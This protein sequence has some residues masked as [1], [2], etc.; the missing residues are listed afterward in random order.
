MN[1]PR[2][3]NAI[4][5]I[6]YK[7][8]SALIDIIDNAVSAGANKVAIYVECVEGKSLNQRNNV[9]TYK[10]VD[11]GHG[12]DK[13]EIINAFKL[14]SNE[15]YIPYSLSKYGM[16]LK[17][18]GFSLGSRIQIVS[19]KNN[20]LSK[21][22]F[23]DQKVI[24]ED[25]DYVICSEDLEENNEYDNLLS[26]WSSGTVVKIKECRAVNHASAKTTINK[27]KDRLGVIYYPFLSSEDNPLEIY[28][29]VPDTKE[30][31]K[32]APL[33][34][35]FSDEAIEFDPVNYSGEYPCRLYKGD[36]WLS[37]DYSINPVKIEVI[38]FPQ[39]KLTH[40]DSPLYEESKERIK[41]YR[42]KRENS[43]FFVYRN[44]RL[45][46]W[47]DTLDIITRNDIVFRARMNLSTEHDELL[48]VDVSKQRLEMDEYAINNLELIMR[49][50]IKQARYISQLCQEIINK[51]GDEGLGFTE[52]ADAVSEDDPAED[53]NPP[54]NREKKKRAEKKANETK[55]FENEMPSEEDESQNSSSDEDLFRRIRYSDALIGTN[56]WETQKDRVNGTYVYINR[57][58]VF[59]QAII[60]SFDETSPARLA[61]EAM[62]Y[63]AAVGE[64]KTFENLTTIDDE[65]I[66][67][68]FKKF[69]NVLSFNISEWANYNH[70]KF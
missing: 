31:F 6:G 56:L 52:T 12:M 48:N 4:S 9:E 42:I 15:N 55:K 59:Y 13:N 35:L 70:D 24:E 49:H 60:A 23:I 22:Y 36:W 38:A 51:S 11:N 61:L 30:P 40:G 26:Y 33:D 14:G 37:E 63:C 20:Q 46:R 68:V 8:H 66:K 21:K 1:A 58:H 34:I 39:H 10:I 69:Y 29:Y 32:V 44:G 3:C 17:S 2:V 64:N 19:K 53:V 57:K 28:I 18:A 43:G 27:L 62:I 67:T 54:D 65:D 16:G 50:P 41:K 25:N 7:P 45:I 47:G 5:R